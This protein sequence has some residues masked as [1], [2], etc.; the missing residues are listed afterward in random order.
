MQ[1]FA[2][3][4]PT[5]GWTASVSALRLKV[6][7]AW[8]AARAQIGTTAIH[9]AR[10]LMIHSLKTC[11]SMRGSAD[12]DQRNLLEIGIMVIAVGFT[13]C[14]SNLLNGGTRRHDGSEI[15]TVNFVKCR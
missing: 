14:G 1:R 2:V 13:F 10:R 15:L 4:L 8:L 11:S 12:R 9:A 3:W 5:A 7:W 6:I